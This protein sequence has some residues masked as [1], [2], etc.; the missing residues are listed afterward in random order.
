MLSG[1]HFRFNRSVTGIQLLNGTASVV[2]IPTGGDIKVLAGPN[3][4]GTVPD[5]GIVYVIWD[6]RTVAIFAVDVEDRGT[7]IAVEERENHEQSAWA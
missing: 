4:N 3:A 2:T 6:E 5:K 7:E 1:K